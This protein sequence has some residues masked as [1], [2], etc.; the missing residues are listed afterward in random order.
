MDDTSQI[1]SVLRYKDVEHAAAW[2]YQAFGFRRRR[3]VRDAAGGVRYILLASGRSTLLIRP[4]SNSDFDELMTQPENAGQA[5]TQVCYLT[6]S[7]L[8]AHYRR[9]AIAGAHIELAPGRDGLGGNFYSCRDLEGHVWSFGT[10]DYE[11]APRFASRLRA[12]L[13]RASERVSML[14][15]AAVAAAVWAFHPGDMPEGQPVVTASTNA[16]VRS[17]NGGQVSHLLERTTAAL[18]RVRE[19]NARLAAEIA[20]IRL[21]ERRQRAIWEQTGAE[22][23]LIQ[24]QLTVER[25]ARAAAVADGA[26]SAQE[27]KALRADAERQEQQ[28]TAL[29]EQLQ[30][31]MAA[32]VDARREPMST[33][34]RPPGIRTETVASP[35][36]E[37]ATRTRPAEA[38]ECYRQLMRGS[39]NW[40]GGTEW[41]PHNAQALCSG[42][43]NARRTIGCFEAGVRAGRP[44]RETITMCRQT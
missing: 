26:K 39:V 10:R 4:V 41:L 32:L 12:G 2:L 22:L 44:W 42:T 36:P 3:V 40:G 43:G 17:E 24:E 30:T 25:K 6:V 20:S 33:G 13:R 23:A 21:H 8:D 31:T 5:S 38:I 7:D 18:D 9:A 16:P 34:E 14:A 28:R 35:R 27:L 19:E 11:T 15:M 1:V 37:R 29:Q